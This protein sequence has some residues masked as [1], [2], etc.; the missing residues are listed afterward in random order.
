[1]RQFTCT[2]RFVLEWNGEQEQSQQPFLRVIKCSILFAVI[3]WHSTNVTVNPVFAVR[4]VQRCCAAA[5]KTSE[6]KV[7]V[8]RSYILLNRHTTNGCGVRSAG[9]EE[10]RHLSS[11]RW[12]L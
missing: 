11:F 10:K 1:M 3:V 7:V 4:I 9:D 5:G 6:R 8:H 12:H 2:Q